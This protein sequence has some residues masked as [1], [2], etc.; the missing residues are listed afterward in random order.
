MRLAVL[1][2]GSCLSTLTVLLSILYPNG[3]LFF[4][5]VVLQLFAVLL[6]RAQLGGQWW[7][8]PVWSAWWGASLLGAGWLEVREGL[9]M[10]P[11]FSSF[12]PGFLVIAVLSLIW[13]RWFNRR[14]LNSLKQS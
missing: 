8:Q 6:T 10:E 14:A 3:E 11:V 12:G 5:S 4:L 9:Q 13:P 7:F 2:L 1:I